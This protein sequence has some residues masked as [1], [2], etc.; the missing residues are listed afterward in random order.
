MWSVDDDAAA[1]LMDEFFS[2]VGPDARRGTPVAYAKAMREA[3]L[4][5]KS[6]PK[7][8]APFYWAP[9]VLIGPP[10]AAGR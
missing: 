3:R 4:K 7:W 8:A 9:F 10:P 1:A 5:V 2:R 6:D